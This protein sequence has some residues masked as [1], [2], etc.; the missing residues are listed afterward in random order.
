MTQTSTAAA[1]FYVARQSGQ[2]N[3]YA[4]LQAAKAQANGLH[5]LGVVAPLVVVAT[6]KDE[7]ADKAQRCYAGQITTR[8]ARSL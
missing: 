5:D 6:S 4:S 8:Q 1:R 7:A 2:I 3:R